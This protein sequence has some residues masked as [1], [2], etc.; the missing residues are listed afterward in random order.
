[1]RRLASQ[2]SWVA[3]GRFALQT[4]TSTTMTVFSLGSQ[5]GK[6]R[7]DSVFF[8]GK[9]HACFAM[10]VLDADSDIARLRLESAKVKSRFMQGLYSKR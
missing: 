8:V 5:V 1:M 4:C 9:L 2:L 10:I 7:L 3:D 6:S